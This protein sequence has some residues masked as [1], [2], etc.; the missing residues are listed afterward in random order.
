MDW[1]AVEKSRWGRRD[2]KGT[3]GRY[4]LA[5]SAYWSKLGLI[6]LYFSPFTFTFSLLIMTTRVMN[7]P[8]D[9]YLCP[10]WH[11]LP[12]ILL[13]SWVWSL[14]PSCHQQGYSPLCSLSPRSVVSCPFYAISASH[15]HDP[16]YSPQRTKRSF[17]DGK[18]GIYTLCQPGYQSVLSEHHFDE[19]VCVLGRWDAWLRPRILLYKIFD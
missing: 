11:W 9:P 12:I 3:G 2:G 5:G 13:R 16:W 17:G 10:L 8:P 1:Q 4:L 6:V 7:G 19:P 14:N 15:L 18:L